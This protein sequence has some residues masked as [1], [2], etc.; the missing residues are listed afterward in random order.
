M[1]TTTHITLSAGSGGAFFDRVRAIAK[2]AAPMTVARLGMLVLVMV[3]IAMTGH[4]DTIEL[5][6][7]NLAQ[8]VLMVCMLIG[9]GMLIGTTIMCA[10]AVG[11]RSHRE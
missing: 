6:Y 7:Y 1:N 8:A 9:V 10:L 11:A 3:D 5:A 4:F 2:L